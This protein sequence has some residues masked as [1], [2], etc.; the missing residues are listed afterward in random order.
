MD[1]AASVFLFVFVALILVAMVY[2][3]YRSRVTATA[4]ERESTVVPEAVAAESGKEETGEQGRE[5]GEGVD[6]KDDPL[7]RLVVWVGY[8]LAV[9]LLVTDPALLLMVAG[10]DEARSPGCM[11]VIGAS[12]WQERPSLTEG[13]CSQLAISRLGWA[14]VLSVAA[15]V[16]LF[17]LSRDADRGN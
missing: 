10:G 15:T 1:T 6:H 14:L 11:P 3:G 12:L 2:A 8:G 7:L 17:R 16:S 13:T 9:A 4:R 5:G